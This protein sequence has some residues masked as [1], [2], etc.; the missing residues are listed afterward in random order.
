[1]NIAS[2]WSARCPHRRQAERNTKA[3]TPR[4]Q[5]AIS[6]LSDE[7]LDGRFLAHLF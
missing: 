3:G 7:E 6:S 4:P 2:G 5:T 1:V